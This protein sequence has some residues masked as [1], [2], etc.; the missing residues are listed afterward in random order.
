MTTPDDNKAYLEYEGPTQPNPRLRCEFNPENLSITLSNSWGAKSKPGIDTPDQSF[1]GG[2]PGVISGLVLFFDTTATGSPVTEYTDK[3]VELMKV[4]TSL[5]GFVEELDNGRPP[6]VKFHWGS[7]HSF[8]AV[9]TELGLAFT[10]F[11]L[12]GEPLRARATLSLK[13]F[14]DDAEHPPQNPTSGTPAP[15]RSHQ[16]QPGETLDRIAARHYGDPTEWRR[17]ATANG[18]RDP[19][20]LRP[21]E[22][23]DIPTRTR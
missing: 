8:R 5:P 15:G 14:T 2:D 10:H 1:Q 17:L 23:V 9:I 21:G 16:V 22:R 19:F 3:L 11:S 4:D 18:I 7:F 13:E 12:H 6:W 20:A